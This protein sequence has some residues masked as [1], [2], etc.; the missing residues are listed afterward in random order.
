[1]E[2]DF[3][4]KVKAEFFKT[5][6]ANRMEIERKFLLKNLPD[7][8]WKF[9]HSKIEQHYVGFSPEV[10]I[11]KIGDAHKLTFK[12]EGNLERQEIEIPITKKQFSELKEISLGSVCKTRYFVEQDNLQYELDVYNNIDGLL[13]VEVEFDTKEDSESFV[14]PEWFGIE[15]TNIKEFKNK[16]LAKNGFPKAL[17]CLAC[18]ETEPDTLCDLCKGEGG[19]KF[20]HVD[21]EAY[22]EEA[23]K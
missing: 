8:L 14:P 22:N 13:T 4:N 17:A 7:Y 1:M 6:N 9:K 20:T 15:I 5:V 23:G 10:R 21:L 18:K 12:S 11:R 3:L 19:L 2:D 16:Y